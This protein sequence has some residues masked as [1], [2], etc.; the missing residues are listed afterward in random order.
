MAGNSKN[1]R[2]SAGKARNSSQHVRTARLPMLNL[3]PSPLELKQMANIARTNLNH[4]IKGDGLASNWM[5]V[6]HRLHVGFFAAERYMKF[7][8]ELEECLCDGIMMLRTVYIRSMN[9]GQ[10][11]VLVHE[12]DKILAALDVTEEI[13]RLLPLSENLDI[14]RYTAAY[15]D[16]LVADNMKAYPAEVL[17]KIASNKAMVETLA[18]EKAAVAANDNQPNMEK[19]A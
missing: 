16:Q 17:E 6:T 5:S 18:K 10:F 7:T 8:E 19:A 11:G 12:L 1:S 13:M 4:L 15:F 14:H 2:K 3:P 9:L